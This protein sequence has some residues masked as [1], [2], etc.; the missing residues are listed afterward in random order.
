MPNVYVLLV[1]RGLPNQRHQL[2]QF[3]LYLLLFPY[4]PFRLQNLYRPYHPY[5]Q[6]PR[7]FLRHLSYLVHQEILL[8]QGHLV[9][10]VPLLCQQYQDYQ[11]DLEPLQSQ[12]NLVNRFCLVDPTSDTLLK[13]LL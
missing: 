12:A 13:V 2:D 6:L 4:H 9:S 10:L 1:L 3:D 8:Y 11:D 7:V 5:L